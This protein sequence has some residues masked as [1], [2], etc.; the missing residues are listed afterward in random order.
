MADN[1]LGSLL[2]GLLG[3]D[4]GAGKLVGALIGA[5]GSGG[6]ESLDGLL[7]QLQEGGLGGKT[8]SWVGTGPNEPLT[9]PEVAQALP[10]QA[11]EHVAGKAGVS[12]EEAA[13]QLAAALPKTI[14]KL[15]PGGQVPE[16]SLEE[17]IARQQQ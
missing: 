6:G 4:S 11:L 12:P 17:L 1:D 9:G 3:G 14:D 7:H 5:L 13:D 8:G 2:G 10:Y 16:G 15:T